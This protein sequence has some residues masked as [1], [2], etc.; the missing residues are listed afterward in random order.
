MLY[1]STDRLRR[2]GAPMENLAHSVSLHSAEKSAPSKPGIKHPR[3]QDSAAVAAIQIGKGIAGCIFST[4][5]RKSPP[6]YN[7]PL[8]KQRHK[9]EYVRQFQDWRRMPTTIDAPHLA[10]PGKLARAEGR[11][12]IR[13]TPS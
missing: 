12:G 6:P 13:R 10:D 9:I 3:G 7:A 5:S 1:R 2:T 4:K 8:H 11:R